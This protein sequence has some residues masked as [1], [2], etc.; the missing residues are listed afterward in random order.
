MLT[1]LIGGARSGKSALALQMASAG[2]PPV[3]FIATAPARDAEM[4]ARISAHRSER[5]SSWSTIEAPV[6]LGQALRE[7]ADDATVVIDC[8]T[9][10]VANLVEAGYD[11]GA[12]TGAADD[13]APSASARSG[14]VVVVSNEVGSG[15]VPMAPLS[16]RYRDLLGRV[17]TAFSQHAGQAFLVMAGRVVPL[18]PAPVVPA[19]SR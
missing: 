2:R 5:P 19:S 14:L 11:D 8:L 18:L 3:T 10:W 13:L 16:R 4:K 12:V 17:N 9:L 1:F 15:I 6:H 7:V